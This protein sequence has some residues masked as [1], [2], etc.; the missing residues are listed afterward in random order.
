MKKQIVDRLDAF[1]AEMKKQGVAAA[2]IPQTDAIWA[3]T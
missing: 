3:S 2:I 1:C